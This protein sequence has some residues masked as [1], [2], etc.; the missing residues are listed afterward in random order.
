MIPE[1]GNF[2][3]TFPLRPNP[4]VIRLRKP[5]TEPNHRFVLYFRGRSGRVPFY[6]RSCSRKYP[7]GPFNGVGGY[8]VSEFGC[9]YRYG[10]VFYSS[11]RRRRVSGPA[12]GVDTS[13]G[14]PRGARGIIANPVKIA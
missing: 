10:H 11:S 12:G 8:F 7:L 1:I 13:P 5:T 4:T 14:L 2:P 9:G 6:H 3:P